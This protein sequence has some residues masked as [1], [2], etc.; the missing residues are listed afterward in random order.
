MTSVKPKRP[1][2]WI[3]D[4]TTDSC[5]LCNTKF[6]YLLRKHHCR[7]CGRIFCYK[8]SSQFIKIPKTQKISRV[9]NKC[10]KRSLF[11][12]QENIS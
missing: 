10:H 7:N 2:Y 3:P 1:V 9:C 5:K 4:S 8:C 12:R 11:R 6:G